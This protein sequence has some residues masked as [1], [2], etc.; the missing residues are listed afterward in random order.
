[1]QFEVTA[2]RMAEV[3]A[4]TLDACTGKTDMRSTGGGGGTRSST[5]GAM[6]LGLAMLLRAT[7]ASRVVP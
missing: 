2:L 1:M 7:S 3:V 5:P 4:L 6:T